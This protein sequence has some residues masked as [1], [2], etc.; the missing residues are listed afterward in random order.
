MKYFIF[1]LL[2]C[3]LLSFNR[4][5]AH[6]I[7]VDSFG[8]NY[9]TVQAGVNAATP[10]DTVLVKPG[11]YNESVV[12]SKSGSSAGGYITLIGENGAILDG[13]G[14]GEV[15]ISI[16]DKNYIRVIGMEIQNFTGSNTPIGIS[17][18]GSSNHLEIR[19]NKVHN[20][21]N[22]NGNA[23]GIAFYGTESTPISDVVVDS[24]E[25][26]NCKLG[27]SESMVFNGNVTN[28]M[29][30]NNLIH[31]N[32]NI[33][34][35]FIGFEGTAPTGYDRARNGVCVHNTVYNISSGSNPAYGGDRSADGIYVDGGENITI[36]RNTVNNCDIGI[37]VASEHKGKNA[38]NIIVRNNFVS[39]SY[40]ANIMTGGYN[41][42]KG[43]ADNIYILN[44]T[45]YHGKQGELVIQFNSDN[46][47]IIN[48]IFFGVP[49][50]P[51]LQA[52]G[53]NNTD[54]NVDNNIYFGQSTSS[55]GSWSD[56]RGIF[57]NPKLINPPTNMNI[58]QGS[59]AINAGINPG[60]DSIG[61]PL[62]GKLD[63][64]GKPRVINDTVDI[65]ADEYDGVTGITS[66]TEGMKQVLL[67]PNPAKNKLYIKNNKG[68]IDKIKIIRMT[69]QVMY[70]SNKPF[71]NTK[72]IDVSGFPKDIYL[73]QINKISGRQ[74]I[75]KFVVE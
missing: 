37:E 45:T 52:W 69:G 8:E 67:F 70:K 17:V 11:I 71:I 38:R 14:K 26:Y 9:T 35:D 60:N 4:L 19:R 22:D 21:D 43:Y 5:F 65:G 15:G 73:L 27:S 3:L 18:E 50:Q 6:T 58:A 24:N 54:I 49:S 10:G 57:A 48:N 53:Y 13:T 61:N 62:Y 33:G 47:Y 46:I 40:L 63:I 44:N 34:I 68:E 39:D 41:Y 64:N 1:L 72:T 75:R 16:S 23:H 29:V 66:Y 42:N 51:Y 30:S 31:D 28:F 25:I 59:P 56:P 12:F 74:F 20:I 7:I 36:E 55:P 2:G 32:D